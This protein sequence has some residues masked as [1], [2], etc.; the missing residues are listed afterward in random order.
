MKAMV[1]AAGLGLRMR[2][3]TLL[4]AKPALPVLNRPLLHWTMERLARAGVREVLV[5]LHH[6]PDTVTGVLGTGRRFG[7][8][9]RYSL[10][11]S[12][13]VR[14]AVFN[15]LGQEVRNIVN[16]VQGEGT[17][18]FE[19]AKLELPSGI[20]FYRIHAPGLSEMKKIII[21]QEPASVQ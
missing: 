16:G 21:T 6:L 8:R 4:R 1:L 2:P 7:L 17:Y 18:E 5:N 13:Y 10:A 14:L 11:R 20:Y 9:I 3:L 12:G 15:M 19:L